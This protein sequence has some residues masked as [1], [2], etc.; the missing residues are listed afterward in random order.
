MVHK[1]G[2]GE[3]RAI[4]A[5]ILVIALVL[6]L[7]LIIVQ[8]ADRDALLYGENDT[9]EFASTES[10]ELVASGG[11]DLTPRHNNIVKHKVPNINLYVKEE[12][13]VIT[14][15]RSV[16][17]AN[18]WFTSKSPKLSF[19]VA[20]V[21][22]LSSLKLFFNVI[23]SKGDLEITLNNKQVYYQDLGNGIATINLPISN[24]K[25]S[26][27]LDFGTN[28]PAA[29]WTTNAYTLGDVTVKQ[30]FSLV[31]SQET[32]TFELTQ[33]EVEN[34]GTA[35]LG[36]Y[37]VCNKR[38]SGET[39]RLNILLNSEEVFNGRINCYNAWQA[40]ELPSREFLENSN[41]LLFILED[42][43]FSFNNLEVKLDL[44]SSIYPKLHF[45]IGTETFEDIQ[46]EDKKAYLKFFFDN[47]EKSKEATII[48]NGEQFI[49]STTES[50][51]IKEVSSIVEEGTNF[52]RIVPETTFSLE[53]MK[54]ILE[55]A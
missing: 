19:N 5:I 29:P 48:I 11:A 13:E 4:A 55:D 34:I 44:E 23:E 53:G 10:L 32:R 37:Q 40:I 2:E 45:S 20:S 51:Y 1:K 47:D 25:E 30:Q 54:V 33:E 35:E 14:L 26:N 8:P 41:E 15:A 27:T 16:K 3:G 18:S 50:T 21:E 31:N 17:V 46:S 43:D 52:V 39:T 24:I 42:G 38:P 22:E 12:P 28:T 36:F 9:A 7:Y 6:I 49:M